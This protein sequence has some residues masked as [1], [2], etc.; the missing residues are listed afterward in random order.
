MMSNNE[1][2]TGRYVDLIDLLATDSD[3]VA[4]KILMLASSSVANRLVNYSLAGQGSLLLN[5]DFKALQL[6]LL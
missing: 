2:L 3:K 5:H 4:D 1:F 6:Y